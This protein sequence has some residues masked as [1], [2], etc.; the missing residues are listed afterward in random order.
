MFCSIIS[1]AFYAHFTTIFHSILFL[2]NKI[3]V[4]I[5][6]SITIW[7]TTI[8]TG[9]QS[10]IYISKVF[11]LL[12]EDVIPVSVV[13]SV[14]AVVPVSVDIHVD[15]SVGVKEYPISSVE[16]SDMGVPAFVPLVF[17][18]V[19]FPMVFPVTINNAPVDISSILCGH[20]T[21]SLQ[22]ISDFLCGHPCLGHPCVCPF[23]LPL[24]PSFSFQCGCPF[25]E[26]N[27][28]LIHS[29]VNY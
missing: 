5:S 16:I 21:C 22:R 20:I 14:V 26:K 4:S 6:F 27:S 10:K 12:V 2:E 25:S 17:S 19:L 24:G 9:A 13:L 8:H 7:G 3:Y 28:F 23:S 11:L 29:I 15:L 1:E 18:L